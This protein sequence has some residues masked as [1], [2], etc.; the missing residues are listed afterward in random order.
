MAGRGWAWLGAA[1]LLGFQL[2]ALGLLLAPPHRR[3]RQPWPM[4]LVLAL[5][6]ISQYRYDLSPIDLW[7]P[8]TGRCR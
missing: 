4:L 2:A 7:P 8:A 6:P 1:G 3:E 5:L